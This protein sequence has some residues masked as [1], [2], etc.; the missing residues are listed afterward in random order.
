MAESLLPDIMLSLIFLV[1][2]S[3][4]LRD[5]MVNNAGSCYL[6]RVWSSVSRN[7]DVGAS[8]LRISECLW[9]FRGYSHYLS[10]LFRGISEGL[11]DWMHCSAVF[12]EMFSGFSTFSILISKNG[13]ILAPSFLSAVFL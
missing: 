12:V 9:G 8:G 7:V 6:D 11:F 3:L 1:V 4:F 2:F 10:V 13:V 5:P